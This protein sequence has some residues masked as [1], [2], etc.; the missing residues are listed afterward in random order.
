MPNATFFRGGR[1]EELKISAENTLAG[2][3]KWLDI[4]PYTHF[5][6][7]KVDVFSDSLRRRVTN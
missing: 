4:N 3:R 1:W 5:K 6:T 2:V 7:V